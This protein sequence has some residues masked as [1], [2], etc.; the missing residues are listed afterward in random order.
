MAGD[1]TVCPFP[2]PRNCCVP[3]AVTSYCQ[4]PTGTP[5]TFLVPARRTVTTPDPRIDASEV[6]GLLLPNGGQFMSATPT[7]L[8]SLSTPRTIPASPTNIYPECRRFSCA[9]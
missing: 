2:S 8:P 5:F 6:P 7:R 9:P 3:C 4:S 1:L